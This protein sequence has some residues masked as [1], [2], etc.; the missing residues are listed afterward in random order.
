[1]KKSLTIISIFGGISLSLIAQTINR[2]GSEIISKKQFERGTLETSIANSYTNN[3]NTSF[4]FYGTFNGKPTYFGFE[5]KKDT[6]NAV[7]QNEFFYSE[8][9]TISK[10]QFKNLKIKWVSNS[11]TLEAENNVV[12][13]QNY[14]STKFPNA[15]KIISS[16]WQGNNTNM[17][18]TT[19]T[20]IDYIKYNKNDLTWEENFD[21]NIS[22]NWLK[23]T[24]RYAECFS[25]N[26]TSMIITDQGN[27]Q[28]ISLSYKTKNTKGIFK[29][30]PSDNKIPKITN[31]QYAN[32]IKPMIVLTFS[33]SIYLPNKNLRNFEISGNKIVKTK[34]KS[35]YKTMWIYLEHRDSSKIKLVYMPILGRYRKPQSFDIE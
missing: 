7:F 35:D 3:I 1:M 27:L 12:L 11:I 33:D 20:E 9:K 31:A 25:K 19:F 18:D 28:L 29:K 23:S 32:E 14:D 5:L 15:L 2:Y 16:I 6:I 17:L 26:D 24:E 8:N 30:D 4:L 34:I 21:Q 10:K 13:S 22:T